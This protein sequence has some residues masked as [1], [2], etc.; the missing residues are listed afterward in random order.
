LTELGSHLDVNASISTTGRILVVSGGVALIEPGGARLLEFRRGTTVDEPS[1]VRLAGTEQEFRPRSGGLR[2]A[3]DLDAD[4]VKDRLAVLDRTAETLIRKINHAHATGVPPAG[5]YRRLT[6]EQSFRDRDGDGDVT[7]DTLASQEFPFSIANGKLTVN[8]LDESDGSVQQTRIP[9]DGETMTVGSLVSALNAVGNVNAVIDGSGRLRVTSDAGFRFDFSHRTATTPDPLG[10]FGVSVTAGGRFTG[11]ADTSYV[12]TPLAPGEIGVTAGLQIGVALPDG[13]PLGVLDVGAGYSPGD[14]LALG[15]GLVVSFGA[16]QIS[17]STSQPTVIEGVLDGDTSG[18]LTALGINGLFSGS[19]AATIEVSAFLQD[20]PTGVAS[21]LGGGAAD[22]GNLARLLAVE[23][24]GD[25]ALDGF[26]IPK[27]FALLVE[28][29][30]YEAARAAETVEVQSVLVESLEQR[31][32]Q[33]SGVAVDEELLRMEEWQQ[34]FE[35]AARFAKTLT[36]I[37]DLLVRLAE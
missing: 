4:L 7:N 11:T 25:D 18:V 5:G 22:A 15:E 19:D 17:P 34:A 36:E 8:V 10:T 28:D 37:S 31:R 12:L 1:Q 20:D 23:T 6:S 3:L 16:G 24:E 35:V 2:G 29:S 13:T 14:E 27:R 33:T 26:D 30:G 21:G 9:I 32:A